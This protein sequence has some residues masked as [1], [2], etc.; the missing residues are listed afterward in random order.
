MADIEK[1]EKRLVE[2]QDELFGEA[3]S[4]Y[5]RAAELEDERITPEDLLMQLYEEEEELHKG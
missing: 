4:D 5:K 1:L 3:A 2:I